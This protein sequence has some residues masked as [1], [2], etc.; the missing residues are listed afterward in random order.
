MMPEI[1]TDENN[2]TGRLMLEVTMCKLGVRR[3]GLYY[4]MCPPRLRLPSIVSNGHRTFDIPPSNTYTPT[5]TS[6]FIAWLELRVP[7]GIHFATHARV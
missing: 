1:V 7:N 4:Q 2:N 3:D 6:V 5:P